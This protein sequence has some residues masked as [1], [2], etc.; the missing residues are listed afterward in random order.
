LNRFCY[1]SCYLEVCVPEET[2][3]PQRLMTIFA[4]PDDES[5]GVA[6]SIAHATTTG[7]LVAVVCATRGEEGQIAD[8]S[9][10]TPETLGQVREQELRTA[11][12]AVGVS[13][14][15][16]L[17]YIDG[18]LAEADQEEALGKVVRQIRRFRPDVVVTFDPKG[19]Y[20]HVDHMAIHR[21]AVAGVAAA[22][23]P[24]RFP[25]HLGE[26]VQPHRVRKVYYSAIPRER[27]L[28]M[29]DEARARGEDFIPGG[30]EATIPVEEMGVPLA[31]I[32]TRIRLN[33]E[34]F[35]GKLNALFAHKTQLPAD[36]PWAQASPEEL[37]A[38]AG[39]ET[40]VLAPPPISDRDYPMPEDDVFASL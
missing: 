26:G 20:G 15:T 14:L 12:A 7:R 6:G 10:A 31:E 28:K 32:R 25:E 35:T 13:D 3:T 1:H 36:N 4:H 11:V 40:F 33:D 38:F 17:D 22:A 8:P 23:D 2:A 29:R 24:A 39:H 5:F 21:L 27:L 9:L 16:F 30:D 37:R 18:H 34:E 19:G